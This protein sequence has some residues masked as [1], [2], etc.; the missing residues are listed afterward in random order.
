MKQFLIILL[1]LSST[2]AFAETRTNER[3]GYAHDLDSDTLIYTET[4]L[5]TYEDNR[6]VS[7]KVTY[8][9]AAGDVIAEKQV[10]YTENNTMPDFSLTNYVTGHQESA[11][12]QTSELTIAFAKNNSEDKKS[13]TIPLPD[14]GIIDA[15]FDQFIISNWEAL[16]N[17]ERLVRKM[18]IPSM[19]QFIEFRIYQE[20]IDTEQQRRILKVEPDSF[21]FRFL[22]DPLVLEYDMAQP[23]LLL[24][25][26]TSNMRDEKGKNL[27]VSISFPIDDYQLSKK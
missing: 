16:V 7:D 6:I 23:K 11:S 22:G 27:Q 1:I 5:E 19:R 17:E 3:T 24:F 4:H 20:K 10:D 21:L 14:I 26:G 8:K 2:Q 25:K 9:N 18:L 13:K 12:K 15:G